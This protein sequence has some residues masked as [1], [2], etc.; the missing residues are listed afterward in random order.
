MKRK[1]CDIHSDG[2]PSTFPPK[3]RPTPR[4]IRNTHSISNRASNKA[5]KPMPLASRGKNTD[6]I[7]AAEVKREAKR[8]KGKTVD[9]QEGV[10]G[11][12]D[13]SF[14]DVDDFESE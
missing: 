13:G 8:F 6:Y 4:A 5:A 12:T 11:D 10:G 7:E 2:V 1:F 3:I 9:V 14:A